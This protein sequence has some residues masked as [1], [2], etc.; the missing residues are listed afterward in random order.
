MIPLQFAWESAVIEPL[1]IL[2]VIP[3]PAGWFQAFEPAFLQVMFYISFVW[4]IIFCSL[5]IWT[6]N[7][8]LHGRIPSLAPLQV[9][10]TIG[11]QLRPL[12]SLPRRRL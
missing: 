10:A 6:V 2:A 4:V 7:S 1:R 11:E 3:S 5:M 12:Y 9:L 8:F